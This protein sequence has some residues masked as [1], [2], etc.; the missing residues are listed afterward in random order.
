MPRVCVLE[1]VAPPPLKGS[2]QAAIG[3][4]NSTEPQ[5]NYG[6]QR[7]ATTTLIGKRRAS[8]LLEERGPWTITSNSESS[9][10]KSRPSTT[11]TTTMASA[12]TRTTRPTAIP[13]QSLSQGRPR[14]ITHTATLQTVLVKED[15]VWSTIQVSCHAKPHHPAT[16]SFPFSLNAPHS[17]K[18]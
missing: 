4:N 9:N 18:A 3:D 14:D 5:H 1:R 10:F 6:M 12:T 7:N 13:K 8:S 11:I 17:S 2:A 15:A 16:T